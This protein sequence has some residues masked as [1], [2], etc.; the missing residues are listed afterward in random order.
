MKT[1]T[2]FQKLDYLKSNVFRVEFYVYVLGKNYF[3]ALKTW[4]SLRRHWAP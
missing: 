4:N 2:Q 1:T 3:I